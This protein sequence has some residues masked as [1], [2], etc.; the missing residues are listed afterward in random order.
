VAERLLGF[1]A[2][3]PYP[4]AMAKEQESEAS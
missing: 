4:V 1:A 2:Q 3:H